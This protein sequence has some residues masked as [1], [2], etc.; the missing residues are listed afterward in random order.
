MKTILGLSAC[1]L[2]GLLSSGC[3]A[4]AGPGEEVAQSQEA[5]VGVDTFLYFRSNATG[6]GVDDATRLLAFG[7]NIWARAY[8]VTE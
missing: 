2:V 7:R 5:V 8:T 1:V 3:S 6:W 4:P